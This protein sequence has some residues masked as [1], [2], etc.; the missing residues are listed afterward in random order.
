MRPVEKSLA[1]TWQDTTVPR[2]R[3]IMENVGVLCVFSILWHK[4]DGGLMGFT[5][6]HD[7]A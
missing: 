2:K 1:E 4:R 5:I 7:T 6:L 3:E